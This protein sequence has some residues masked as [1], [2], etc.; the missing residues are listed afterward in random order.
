LYDWAKYSALTLLVLL[1]ALITWDFYFWTG[2]F[3]L[4]CY[5]ERVEVS[6]LSKH[7]TLE[8]LKTLDVDAA[9]SS[10][11]IL[12]MEGKK[13]KFHPSEIGV[14]ISPR[15]TILNS[16]GSIYRT[17][18]IM[19]LYKR[20]TENYRKVV[21]PFA[22]EVN[23]DIYR[24]VLLGLAEEVDTQTKEATFTL[25]PDKS[26]KITKERPGKKLQ[27]DRSIICLKE[28]LHLNERSASIEISQ[29]RPR[30]YAKDLAKYPPKE[31]LAEFTT[32]YGSH[33]SPNRVHNIKLAASKT[34]DYVLAS[35]EVFSL[36]K[37]LGDFSRGSGYKEAF[38]LYNGELEP[39]YGGGSCQIA[40]TLYNAALLAGLEIVER[41][42]HGIY[43]TIY[44][45]GRDASIYARSR[46][47]KIRNNSVHPIY[48]RSIATDKKLSY[49][50]Y[51]SPPARKV[52]F[53]RPMIF[54]E[55]EKFAP[56]NVMTEE[57]KEKIN[58]ALLSGLPYYSYVK[59]T[60]QHAGYAT[61]KLIYSH[62]KMTGDRENVKIVRPEP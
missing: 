7:E 1:I 55:G 22:L 41:H 10:P 47:L 57:S 18:Y 20:L 44:P 36:L 4:D 33:D 61:E 35:G 16:N 62:Y 5:I 53:S 11:I 14:Y 34:N 38:V 3:P 27:V 29:L 8:K 60:T 51:G 17:N 54:F 39:Q 52:A 50:I 42:N 43:F 59:V 45:L 2:R 9:T 23:E 30:V 24:S 48:I 40:S 26:Y 13:L 58:K 31:Q 28:A 49:A 37:M 25:L 21:I 15:R 32:Y 46:D 12:L 6:G 19:D 56:Y